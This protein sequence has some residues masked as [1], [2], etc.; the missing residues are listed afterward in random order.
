MNTPGKHAHRTGTWQSAEGLTLFYRDFGPLDGEG[1]AVLCLPGLTRNSRDFIELAEHLANERRV[2]CPDLRGRGHSQHDP[3]WRNY[4]PMSYVADTWRLL[5]T[6]GLERVVVIGTSLGGLMAMIMAA[7]QPQRLAGVVL[8]DVGPEIAPEGLA[9]IRGYTGR[10]P[11]VDSWEGAVAQARQIYG[12]ALPDLD[13]ARWLAFARQ[14]FRENAE[15][16]PQLDHDPAIGRAIAEVSGEPP[17]PWPLFRALSMPT[18]ALRGEF[19]DI[20]SPATLAR[21]QQEKPDL[22]VVTVANRGHVP[23]LDEP[24]S[25]AAIE[26]LLAELDEA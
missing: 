22:R 16:V 9:R 18:L 20:L 7:Q 10:L 5:D 8:N 4:Q 3:E 11:A 2:V 26:Q 6:L 21:M 24:E 17:D 1:V 15:G 23:L 13:D 19:S 25:L 14:G 12:A